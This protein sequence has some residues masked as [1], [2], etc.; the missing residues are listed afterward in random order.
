MRAKFI[1]EAIKHLKPRSEE[2]LAKL[3][4]INNYSQLCVWP[5]T[6]LGDHPV[7]ELV[8]FFKDEM[9]VRIKFMEEV[10]TLPG[11]GG[12]GGRNDIFFYVHDDDI[13]KFAIPRLKMGIRWW[14]DVLNNQRERIYPKEIYE[15]YPK[16]W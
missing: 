4:P 13:E 2:E 16:K 14:E 3:P 7:Q 8:D 5:G 12:E 15:K 10:K 6:I 9:N 1:L 11:D